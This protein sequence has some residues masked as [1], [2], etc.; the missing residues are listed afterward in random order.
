MNW[1]YDLQAIVDEM[2]E[3]GYLGDESS[4][5]DQRRNERTDGQE[6]DVILDET[7]SEGSCSIR[8]ERY[9]E[10]ACFEAA[11]DHVLT[12]RNNGFLTTVSLYYVQNVN[13][14]NLQ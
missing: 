14:M 2:P 9:R 12:Y 3:E 1:S 10:A 7:L 4:I 8:S 6:K 11:T 13:K 5:S